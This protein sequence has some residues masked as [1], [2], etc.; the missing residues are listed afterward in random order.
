MCNSYTI[1][2]CL[3]RIAYSPLSER[4]TEVLQSIA[5]GK[6]YSKIALDLFISRE[7]VRSHIKNIYQKPAVNRKS[8]ALKIAGDNKWLNKSWDQ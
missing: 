7:T 5:E 1:P 2:K 6:S 8:D 3:H 4:E